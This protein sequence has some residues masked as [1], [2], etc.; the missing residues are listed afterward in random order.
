MH[1]ISLDDRDSTNPRTPSDICTV[2]SIRM[3]R[4]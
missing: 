1:P 2:N 3:L 4:N